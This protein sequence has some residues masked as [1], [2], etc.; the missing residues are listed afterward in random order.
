LG[1]LRFKVNPRKELR[2]PGF[3]KLG[4]VIHTCIPNYM[5]SIVSR[6]TVIGHP[7]TKSVMPPLS[8]LLLNIVLEFLARAIR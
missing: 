1:G 5:G 8:P 6:I 3:N 2:R 7:W 4:V